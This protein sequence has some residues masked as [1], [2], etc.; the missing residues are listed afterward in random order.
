MKRSRFGILQLCCMVQYL[1]VL[2]VLVVYSLGNIYIYIY[3]RI[4]PVMVI[5]LISFALRQ[6]IV[7]DLVPTNQ[8][9]LSSFAQNNI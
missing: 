9:P 6:G 1:I 2:I 4:F 8:I 3:I 7:H 5:I